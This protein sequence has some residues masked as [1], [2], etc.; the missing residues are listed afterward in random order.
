MS[1][2]LVVLDIAENGVAHLTLNRPDAANAI[3]LDLAR[4]LAEAASKLADSKDARAVLLS[5]RGDRF[6]GGGDVRAFATATGQGG[7]L[8]KRLTG[9]VGALHEAIEA[10]DRLDAPIV[11]AVQGSAAGAGL[12]LVALSDLVI[13][14]RSAK[15]V[16]AYTAIGLTPDGGSTWYLPRIVGLRRA[17]ELTLTNRVLS[18]EEAREWGLVTSVVPDDAL[19]A[20]AE[21]LVT[22]LAAG[23][24]R[25]FGVA[26][27]LLRGS[28]GAGLRDQLANEEKELIAAGGRDDAEEGVTA[29]V[30]KR[31]PRFGAG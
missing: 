25:S 4:A 30:E 13:A 27:R 7:A 2:A 15:F 23:P 17:I 5:G 20:E 28:L 16:M 18:A 14:A 26:K 21:A 6:C 24:T 22:K 3:N 12:S 8:P 29:F 1:E 11:S 10:F 31:P 19:T 9:I